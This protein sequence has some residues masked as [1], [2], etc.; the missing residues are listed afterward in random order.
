MN[1]DENIKQQICYYSSLSENSLFSLIP[2]YL[3]EYQ[4]LILAPENLVE[5]GKTYFQMHIDEF[6]NLV[7]KEFNWPMRRKDP[8][9]NDELNLVASIADLI[10]LNLHLVVPPIIIA[11]LLIKI[12]LDKLCEGK[13]LLRG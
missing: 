5:I 9:F 6:R 4:N 10:I 1:V 11:V 2:E 13:D 8:R 7:C 12:G 3:P